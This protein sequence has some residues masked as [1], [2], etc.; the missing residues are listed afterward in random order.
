MKTVFS[1]PLLA[2]L[3]VSAALVTPT[4][5]WAGS[6]AAVKTPAASNSAPT[7][8]APKTNS[9]TSQPVTIRI[10]LSIDINQPTTGIQANEFQTNFTNDLAKALGVSASQIQI[11]NVNPS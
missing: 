8:P 6:T 5:A 2:T 11:L 1:A 3:T 4:L 9:V 10:Q 7:P